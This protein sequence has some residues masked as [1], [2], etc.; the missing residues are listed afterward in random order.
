MLIIL[1]INYHFSVNKVTHHTAAIHFQ[2]GTASSVYTFDVYYDVRN[3]KCIKC[4][5]S[6]TWLSISVSILYNV[7]NCANS[8]LFLTFSGKAHSGV[9]QCARIISAGIVRSFPQL[10]PTPRS[11]FFCAFYI[12]TA[13]CWL[14][15]FRRLKPIP[16][17]S[18][19]NKDTRYC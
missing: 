13:S 6:R 14:S 11:R 9:F 16:F 17:P 10:I 3:L 2:Y 4:I 5:Y 7:Y 19:N 12:P 15:M 18:E 1:A 8:S